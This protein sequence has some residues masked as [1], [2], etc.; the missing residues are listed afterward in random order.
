MT[1]SG[2][3]KVCDVKRSTTACK[4]CGWPLCSECREETEADCI[5]RVGETVQAALKMPVETAPRP[6]QG[7]GR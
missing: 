6:R 3:C 4:G 2:Y 1:R 5:V 7:Q